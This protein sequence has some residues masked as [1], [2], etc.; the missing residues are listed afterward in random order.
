MSPNFWRWEPRRIS[1]LAVLHGLPRPV[2][3]PGILVLGSSAAWSAVPL[4]LR[5]PGVEIHAVV[6]DAADREKL[7]EMATQKGL[8]GFTVWSGLPSEHTGFGLICCDLSRLGVS[9]LASL[10]SPD[11]LL[12]LSL[13]VLPGALEN[14]RVQELRGL[15][16]SGL[17]PELEQTL[18]SLPAGIRKAALSL[19]SAA[20]SWANEGIGYVCDL[21]PMRDWPVGLS[22]AQAKL[23]AELPE[24]P[25]L[26]SS[27]L[28]L[29]RGEGFRE[30]IFS[31][32]AASAC[33]P[34][35]LSALK[36]CFF[37]LKASGCRPVDGGMLLSLRDGRSIGLGSDLD[38]HI[39][40][41]LSSHCELGWSAIASLASHDDEPLLLDAIWRLVCIEAIDI[42]SASRLPSGVDP[43][44]LLGG[45]KTAWGEDACLVRFDL[46]AM[47][48][49]AIGL[50]GSALMDHLV[51]SAMDGG[52][53]IGTGTA[54]CRDPLELAGL[55]G[56]VLPGRLERL[57]RMGG[58]SIPR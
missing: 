1:A 27:W 18:S 56:K 34:P 41:A 9:S 46:R 23:H 14:W 25:L 26:R 58:F 8:T 24:D 19:R 21:S 4:S 40:Q 3:E 43:W 42:S 28:D 49:L 13:S 30:C 50:D 22:P 10:L 37:H 54:G 55:I 36:D 53:E 2:F 31:R 47:E 12:V 29:L 48:G 7:T 39:C 33:Y 5:L 52:F 32:C 6:E 11:G 51:A 57:E 20:D 45:E 15:T 38:G 44:L 17:L 35:N 16:P